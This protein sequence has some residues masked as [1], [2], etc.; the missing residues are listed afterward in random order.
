VIFDVG[1]LEA[2]SDKGVQVN[3][4][5]AERRRRWLSQ[6]ARGV[7]RPDGQSFTEVVQPDTDGDHQRHSPPVS[8]CVLTSLVA[9][10]QAIDRR[11]D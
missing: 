2:L 4:A 7:G 3:T 6:R 9:V 1:N 8:G 5:V 10:E 11:Q